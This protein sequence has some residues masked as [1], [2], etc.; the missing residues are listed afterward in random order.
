[1]L[2]AAPLTRPV[3]ALHDAI[4]S[5]ESAVL[6]CLASP[7]KRSVHQIRTRT[8]RIEALLELIAMLPKAPPASKQRKKALN[9]LKKLRR[10]AGT[11]RDLDVERDLTAQESVRAKG[12]SRAARAIQ[13]EARVFRSHLKRQRDESADALTRLLKKQ[14]KDLPLAMRDLEDALAPMEDATLSEEKLTSLVRGWYARC[15]PLQPNRAGGDTDALHSIRKRAKHARY[16]AESAPKQA[17]RA[18]RLAARFEALQQSGGEWHDWLQ[19][20]DVAAKHLGKSAQLSQYFG[21]RAG[22]ALRSYRQR[23]A[24]P[25]S[26]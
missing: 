1:M 18:H 2:R 9:L 3:Q 10:A 17:A 12:S 21:S 6:L 11:V 20:H 14:Q 25:I 4:Q 5:L 23:L 13:D 22:R 24:K 19:L 15:N 16:M 7:K 8:R 26:R